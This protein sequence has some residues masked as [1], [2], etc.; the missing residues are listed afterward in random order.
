MDGNPATALSRGRVPEP[1][2]NTG[3]MMATVS[4]QGTAAATSATGIQRWATIALAVG[5]IV[6][7]GLALALLANGFKPVPPHEV[8]ILPSARIKVSAAPGEW[9]ETPFTVENTGTES[10]SLLGYRVTC[11]C[12]VPSGLPATLAPGESV[13]LPM[14]VQMIQLKEGETFQ[15]NIYLTTNVAGMVPVV[16][17]VMSPQPAPG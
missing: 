16:S 4:T 14:R 12:T 15:S 6:F 3:G 13:E 8:Q 11:G 5:A 9:V 10:I 2:A 7:A 17:V 1:E